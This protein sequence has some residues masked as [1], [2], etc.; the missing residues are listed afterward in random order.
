[1]PIVDRHLTARLRYRTHNTDIYKNALGDKLYWKL[2]QL[3]IGFDDEIERKL[4]LVS[5]IFV[6]IYPI[7]DHQRRDVGY[8]YKFYLN[9]PEGFARRL[10]LEHTINTTAL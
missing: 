3:G 8:H 4:F 7:R 10:I 2:I 5:E 6:D 1:M 9:T